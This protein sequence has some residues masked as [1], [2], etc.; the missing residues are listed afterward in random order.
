MAEYFSYS[1][2]YRGSSTIQGNT[3][4]NTHR[5][6][7]NDIRTAENDLK[8]KNPYTNSK[9]MLSTNIFIYSNDSIVGMIQS[10][11]VNE[12]RQINKLQAIGWEGVVQAV[13]SNT[14]GGSLNVNRIALYDSTLFSALGLT[15]TGSGRNE[16][17]SKIHT[18][19]QI[20]S[21]NGSDETEPAVVANQWDHNSYAKGDDEAPRVSDG[22]VFRTLRD[23]RAPLEI[24][25]RT[26]LKGDDVTNYYTCLYIDCW[27]SSYSRPWSTQQI[28]VAEQATIQ[29]GDV[30]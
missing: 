5:Y 4:L 30:Y 17:G 22:L 15:T 28:T 26:P 12:Q 29:Y 25:V 27:L 13:P 1:N 18:L 23:Q 6:T 20:P 8:P 21:E 14:R 2:Y 16:L 9:V 7:R 11:T 10:F 19:Q 3:S 24:Q